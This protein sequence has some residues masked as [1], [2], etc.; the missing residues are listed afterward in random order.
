MKKERLGIREIAE[1]AGVSIATVS[2]VINNPEK[3]TKEIRDRVLKVVNQ[4][5]Y[6]PNTTASRLFSKKS[7]SFALFVYDIS[8]PYFISLIKNLGSI[9]LQNKCTLLICDTESSPNREQEYLHYCESIATQGII[10]TEGFLSNVIFER[11]TQ[12][13]VFL[14]RN[15]DSNYVT[16]KSDNA[17]GIAMLVDYLHNL[18]HRR[19]GFAGYLQDFGS[20]VERYNAFVRTIEE[21]G[22]TFRKEHVFRGQLKASTGIAAMDYYCSIKDPPTAIV[23]ANDQVAYGLCMRALQIG[24]RIPDDLSVVGFDGC[25]PDYCFPR[26]T[27]IRQNTKALARELFNAIFS[28]EKESIKT[29]VDVEFVVGDS[30]KKI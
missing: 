25:M 28:E 14:D 4:Y 6:V 19:I 2:R 17:K 21:K 11:T 23:C 7:S 5:K 10:L 12:N 26:I 9:A 16:I 8:N 18:G 13:L 22:M 20:C 30:C 29:T 15:V 1:L 3:T 24:F 27:S